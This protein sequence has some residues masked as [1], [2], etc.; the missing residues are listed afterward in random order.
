[1]FTQPILEKSPRDQLFIHVFFEQHGWKCLS[2]WGQHRLLLVSIRAKC[3]ANAV[4]SP[5]HQIWAVHHCKEN[6]KHFK[7]PRL[8]FL[9]PAL[10]LYLFSTETYCLINLNKQTSPSDIN[11]D[12][13]QPIYFGKYTLSHPFL[14]LTIHLPPLPGIICVEDSIY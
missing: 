8:L 7:S 11:K 14:H 10:A 2:R 3:F 4:Q 5:C 9:N 6:K 1:M 13:G 12:I